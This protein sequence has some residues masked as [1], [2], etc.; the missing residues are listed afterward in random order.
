MRANA[1]ANR[2]RI[3]TAAR[4]VF[5]THGVLGSTE[6][7]AARA[8]VGIATVFRHFPTKEALLAAVL[9][10]RLARF[11]AEA[12]E[13]ATT[14]DPRTALFEVLTRAVDAYADKHA[15]ADALTAAGVD[16]QPLASLAGQALLRT[17]GE[18]LAGAQR[19][20][21]VRPDIE[22]EDLVALLV[23][24]LRAAEHRSRQAVDE[25]A[26]R[27][28]LLTVFVDGLRPR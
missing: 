9:V 28:R 27:R 19:A 10:D 1:R 18:L 25:P 14:G 23:G 6:D 16:A 12:D 4:D 21:A 7:V 22:V 5:G 17:L 8:G 13:L 24:T 26:A 15:I 11:A 2:E 3:V 20:G